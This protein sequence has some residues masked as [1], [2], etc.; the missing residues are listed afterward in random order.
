LALA[1]CAAA[2]PDLRRLY[3]FGTA[4]AGQPPV[5]VIPGILGSRLRDATT[6]EELWPGS[7]GS[8]VLGSKEH[9]AL[10]FDPQT[11]Q[12]TAEASPDGLFEAVL[13]TDFYGEILRTLEH[14][15]GYRR[16]RPGE[17]ADARQRRYYVFAYDWRQDNV[18]TAARLDAFI[19][20][21]RRDYGDPQL[22]VDIVAHS[23][24]G[25]VTRY[26]LRYGDEDVLSILHRD[27]FKVADAGASKVR[28]AILLGT[29][30]LGSASSL[31]GFIEGASIGLRR[32]PSD[33][34]ATMPSA[35]QLFPHP[36]NDWLI[37]IRGE[38]VDRDVFDVEVWRDFQWSVFS[39]EA[40]ARAHERGVDPALLQQVFEANLERARRFVW[41]LSVRPERDAGVRIV[42]FGGDCSL[43][44]AR[45]L[46]EQVDGGSVARLRP[47]DI[48]R[49]LPGV[50]YGRMMLEPGDSQ[51]TKPSLLAREKL[52]PTA[53]RHRWLFF[54]LAYS[55]FLCEEHQKLTGNINFQDNL[56]NVLLSRERPWDAP[57]RAVPR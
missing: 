26:F 37:D 15:G 56:L 27:D 33:V 3:E 50:D 31:H 19:G 28:T 34:L 5:I 14:S 11:L 57:A 24:G 6:G 22:K 2:R 45:L 8:L 52:D 40:I 20:Q 53:E 55:F 42:V 32:I 29:P 23:M 10:P 43:T 21:I 35:F 39:P 30:N 51:V 13:G 38:P 44:P 25:L 9:L 18:R 1:A 41:S 47:D 54:P 46:V 4:P 16:A 12:P 49:P 48:A 7:L 17:P 36:I